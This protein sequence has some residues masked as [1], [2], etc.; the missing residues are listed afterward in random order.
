MRLLAI[1]TSLLMFV[2]AAFGQNDHG[3][4]AGSVSDPFGAVL[5][6]APVQAK[7]VATGTVYKASSTTSGS[8][9]VGDL[10]A[11]TYDVSV[12]IPGLKGYEHKGVAVTAAKTASLNIRLEEGTQLSTLG[13]NP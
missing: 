13:E 7:N 4:I 1:S 5:A 11:G 2:A 8:Y 12:T 10:P 9:T 6:S 3:A